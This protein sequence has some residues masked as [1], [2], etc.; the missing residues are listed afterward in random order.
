M[1]RGR[2]MN[3]VA[4]MRA[5]AADWFDLIAPRHERTL[6]T[7][8]RVLEDI[9]LYPIVH[10]FTEARII[11][12]TSFEKRAVADLIKSLKYDRSDY[13]AALCAELLADYLIE[14]IAAIR[15]F[16]TLPIYLLPMP[17]HA[18]RRSERGFNQIESIFNKLP[19]AFHSGELARCETEALVRTRN[20]KTQTRL[21]RSERLRNVA[22]AFALAD[23]ATISG[24]HVFLIDDVTTTG[25]TLTQAA[26]PLAPHVASL[27]LVALARA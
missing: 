21:S 12:I 10:E 2:F 24:A 13:A 3:S 14:E 23:A 9:P 20:T 26:T 5:L 19:E 8:R 11:T 18:T 15:A 6:R 25:A 16:S 22:D 1:N 27:T 17:L 7:N 4:R